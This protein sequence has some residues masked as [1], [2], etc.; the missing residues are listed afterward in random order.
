MTSESQLETE[1]RRTRNMQLFN[2][3]LNVLMDQINGLLAHY[4]I[5]DWDAYVF[6][7]KSDCPDSYVMKYEATAGDEFAQR[8][9]DL[10]KGTP[11]DI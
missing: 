7:R 3:D 11:S 8:I 10:H 5:G 2:R 1:A 9:V 6:F 4:Q